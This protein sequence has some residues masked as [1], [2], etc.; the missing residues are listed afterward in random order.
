MP[1]DLLPLLA[2]L[3]AMPEAGNV[4]ALDNEGLNG[5]AILSPT[6]P[7]SMG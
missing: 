4:P 1:P 6:H 5:M 3:V 7:E 2:D